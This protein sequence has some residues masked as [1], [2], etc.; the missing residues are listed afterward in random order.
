MLKD[1]GEFNI[2]WHYHFKHATKKK[3]K[4]KLLTKSSSLHFFIQNL[5]FCYIPQ[6]ASL[7]Y[8]LFIYL[9]KGR[10]QNDIWIIFTEF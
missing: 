7:I 4:Q 1:V 6:L 8:D 10:K 2:T 3:M 9:W 5:I